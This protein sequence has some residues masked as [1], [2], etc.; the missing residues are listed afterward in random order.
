MFLL[1]SWSLLH[2]DENGHGEYRD[3]QRLEGYR[4]LLARV[5]KDYDV[6]TTADFL[7]LVARGKIATTHEVDLSLAEYKPPPK[8]QASIRT[9]LPKKKVLIKKGQ[10]E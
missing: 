6:I 4:K 7:D 1:H 8:K 10:S 2:W 5:S 9:T 3:N